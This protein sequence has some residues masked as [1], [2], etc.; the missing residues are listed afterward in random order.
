MCKDVQSFHIYF[1][2]NDFQQ[3]TVKI[4]LL[5][6]TTCIIPDVICIVFRLP[7][8]LHTKN[9]IDEHYHRMDDAHFD[10]FK[11]C[12]PLQTQIVTTKKF[13]LKLKIM[14]IN[15]YHIYGIFH[16]YNYQL[17]LKSFL[18]RLFVSSFLFGE[19]NAFEGKWNAKSNKCHCFYSYY[20]M[21]KGFRHA[22]SCAFISSEKEKERNKHRLLITKSFDLF[23]SFFPLSFDSVPFCCYAAAKWTKRLLCKSLNQLHQTKWKRFLIQKV[24]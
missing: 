2:N 8:M 19:H 5:N 17:V 18:F 9:K 20:W 16:S 1:H 23:T 3:Y 24:K 14:R 15:L 10:V 7:D 22:V 6:E 4:V 11:K 13:Q 12:F 21:L